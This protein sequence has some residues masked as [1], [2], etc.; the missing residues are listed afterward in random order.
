MFNNDSDTSV[1]HAYESSTKSVTV[2]AGRD[3]KPGEQARQRMML[4]V[5]RFQRCSLERR[6][7]KLRSSLV[8]IGS[9]IGASVPMTLPGDGHT[10]GVHQL[11]PR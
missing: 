7:S 6:P 2:L 8:T 11:R 3:Y 4:C 10:S 5:G 9:V 1:C